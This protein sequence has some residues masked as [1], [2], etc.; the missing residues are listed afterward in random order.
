M[1]EKDIWEGLGVAPDDEE[2]AAT[3]EPEDTDTVDEVDIPGEEETG[4]EEE[5]SDDGLDEDSGDEDDEPDPEAAHQQEL[6]RVRQEGKDALN[7]QVKGMKLVDP[8]HEN[9]PITNVEELEE[10]K[11]A[12]REA[13]IGRYCK[14]AGITREQFDELVGELPEV[15]EAKDAKNRAEAA[16]KAAQEQQARDRLNAEVAKIRELCPEIKDLE[17]LVAHKSYE[18]VIARMK[19]TGDG[20][21]DAFKHV[22]FEELMQQKANNT[23]RQAARNSRGKDHL[24]GTGG[25][26]K[27]GA[28]IPADQLRI[29]Q[30]LNPGASLEELQNFHAA[31]NKR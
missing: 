27:G 22:N 13:K 16:E 23:R 20:V 4:E 17:T 14:A 1:D 18:K 7:A 6:A 3:Q 30:R 24:R 9:K 29:Y 31:N 15:R 2:A 28:S 5:G 12:D 19:A 11:I 8:Y 10:Y 25:K 26:G 21:L